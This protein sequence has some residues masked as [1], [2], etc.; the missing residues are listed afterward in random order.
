MIDPNHPR[1][2]SDVQAHVEQLQKELQTRL[3]GRVRNLKLEWRQE[4]LLLR[5]RV[6]T[7]HA[8]QLVQHE[9]MRA[10]PLPLYANQIE[11]G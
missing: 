2:L 7:Y 11:V 10:T 4:G 1:G 9:V 3:F 5:G 6:S 8:K